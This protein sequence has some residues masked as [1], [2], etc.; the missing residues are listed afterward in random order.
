MRSTRWSRI[1][2]SSATPAPRL[3]PTTQKPPGRASGVESPD[4][5]RPAV[6]TG[7]GRGR[8]RLA[9][10]GGGGEGHGH[11]GNGPS[12][13]VHHPDDHGPRQGTARQGAEIARG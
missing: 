10:A 6:R 3:P 11:T 7:G 5:G 13:R 9:V 2:A 8:I 4:G 12:L 1:P